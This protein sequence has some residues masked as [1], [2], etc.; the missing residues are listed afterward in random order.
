[1][2][3]LHVA[4]AIEGEYHRHCAVTLRSVLDHCGELDV[5][6]HLL[7][8][9]ELRVRHRRRLAEMVEREGGRITAIEIPDEWCAGLPIRG[10]T[11]KA[12]WY[13]IFLPDILVDL[14]RVLYLDSDLFVVDDLTPLWATDI[15]R[16]Y[17]A[18]VTNV[19]QE[20]DFGHPAEVGIPDPRQYFNAGVL[21]LNLDLMRREDMGH[22]L[23]EFSV[24]NANRLG[25][26]DQDALNLVLGRRRLALHP[27]WNL[28]NSIVLFPWASDLLGREAVE[29]ALRD[30]A[31]RHYEGP[32]ENKPWHRR[33]DR[34]LRHQ[35]LELRRRTPWPYYQL[36]GRT[37]GVVVRR[38]IRPA[39]PFWGRSRRL[40]GRIRRGL[41]ERIRG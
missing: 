12:T 39:R 33:S 38:L 36:E 40:L 23:R 24:T 10:F 29:E 8:P 35:Y 17:V 2:S 30:P 13:R 18:A 27:R 25:W 28:M 14:D 3:T 11:G 22:A 31:I 20:S 41:F 4:C 1:M 16:H 5:E 21:L 15:S 9:P 7:H 6:V 37:P 34:H 19:L 32:D 26:R